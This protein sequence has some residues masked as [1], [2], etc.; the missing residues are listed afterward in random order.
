MTGLLIGTGF[1]SS[2]ADHARKLDFLHLWLANT[3]SLPIVIVDNSDL[4]LPSHLSH[5]SHSIRVLRITKNLGHMSSLGASSHRLL[6][7][8]LAWIIS[9]LVAYSENCD[10]IYQEQDCLAFGDWLPEIRRGRASFGNH[11]T[12]DCEQSLVYIERNFIPGFLAAYLAIPES[13][14]VCLSE[15][16]YKLLERQFPD[17]ICRH[18]LQPGRGRPLPHDSRGPWTAQQFTEPE[19][20]ALKRAGLV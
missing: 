9:A 15:T 3:P 11:A 17:D 5:P 14:A 13:D 18:S 2:A 16:K 4:G 6:G 12:M 1:Y 19:L 7:G 8:S 20:D 10:Y